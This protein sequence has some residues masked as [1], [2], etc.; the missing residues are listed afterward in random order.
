M[1]WIVWMMPLML[2]SSLCAQSQ[3]VK[4]RYELW[5]EEKIVWY[6][7]KLEPTTSVNAKL[8]S[9]TKPLFFVGKFIDGK[10]LFVLTTQNGQPAL[11]ADTDADNDL[12]DEQPFRIRQ[13]GFTQLFGPFPMRFRINER[14]VIQHFGVAMEGEGEQV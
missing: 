7:Q 13:R 12:T 5:W 8:P 10:R 3:V 9:L 14:T 11:Y 6:G 1:R 4:L 2:G